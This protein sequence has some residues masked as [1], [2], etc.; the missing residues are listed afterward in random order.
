MKLKEDEKEV[1]DS[2]IAEFEVKLSDLN[3]T[4]HDSKYEKL[5]F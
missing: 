1:L 3:K 5:I 2:K 4:L